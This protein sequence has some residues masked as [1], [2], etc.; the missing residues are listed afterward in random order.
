MKYSILLAVLS[1]ILVI[2]TSFADGVPYFNQKIPKIQQTAQV[3]YINWNEKHY[4]VYLYVEVGPT[5]SDFYWVIPF[6]RKP[7]NVQMINASK[8]E[9]QRKIDFFVNR[10]QRVENERFLLDD[11]FNKQKWVLIANPIMVIPDVL[12][13]LMLGIG[14]FAAGGGG[15]AQINP[16]E[17][18]NFGNL[19]SASVYKGNLPSEIKRVFSENSK[20]AKYKDYDLIVF[21]INKL[22]KPTGLLVKMQFPSNGTLFYP[23][24]T[25]ELWEGNKAESF[26]VYIVMP[27]DYDTS[28]S[29][30][31]WPATS[32]GP[33]R[34][35]AYYPDTY[36]LHSEDIKLKI[37]H[38]FRL[39]KIS[40]VLDLYMP[41][42][43]VTAVLM[44]I[45]SWTTPYIIKRKLKIKMGFWR[46]SW[47]ALLTT[48]FIW[49][50]ML[51]ICTI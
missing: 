42:D 10:V 36:T 49:P 20:L 46:Y 5:N 45:I 50:F 4:D 1:I 44:F 43:T 15:T 34:T 18:Y 33:F 26:S 19:G 27:R 3:V 13:F 9:F 35:Y 22:D 47:Y 11:A 17:T 14:G 29:A 16:L 28:W 23:S 30:N 48:I 39:T 24:G 41:L 12:Y 6:D 21:H 7:I 38:H 8:D 37:K 31:I 2:S 51:L 25:T 32:Y 40:S